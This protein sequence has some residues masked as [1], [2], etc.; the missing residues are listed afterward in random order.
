MRAVDVL[1]TLELLGSTQWGLVTTFQAQEAGVS[2]MRL[3]RLAD[4]GTLQ[5]VR[6]GVYAL[7]S[8]GSQPL[9]ELRAAWLAIS[10]KLVEKQPVAV[11][12][13]ES[14]A[15][16][17][18]LGD[19][20]PTKH[21]FTTAVRRQ[22]TLP[23]V[24]YRKRA[25]SSQDSTRVDGLPVTTVARTVA[26]LAAAQTD[27]DH[28]AAVVHDALTGSNVTSAQLAEALEPA[29]GRFGY[30]DGSTVLTALLE[31]VGYRPGAVELSLVASELQKSVFQSV[32]PHLQDLVNQAMFTQLQV[33]PNLKRGLVPL[34]KL[35]PVLPP[36]PPKLDLAPRANLSANALASGPRA[37]GVHALT[38]PPDQLPR[39]KDTDAAAPDTAR[40]SEVAKV[41]RS[42]T[43]R[44]GET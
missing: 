36:L 4:V 24:R 10:A 23:D 43:G 15:A 30:A 31:S 12:S 20:L 34:V 28:L 13:G 35:N 40:G 19:L 1:E 7:P 2:K 37:E 21:E 8:A 39:K 14:A 22:T 6:H 41:A 33:L 42:R 38:R 27:F 11:V 18:G 32:T 17:H 25:L 3:S 26:D 44:R 9:Q 16:V 5:R 29:A